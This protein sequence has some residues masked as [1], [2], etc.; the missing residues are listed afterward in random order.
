M[1]NLKDLLVNTQNFLGFAYWIEIKTEI[2]ACTYYFGPFQSQEEA[3]QAQ[4]GYE[5]DL[6]AEAAQGISSVIKQCKP[7][8]LTI[9]EDL[10][11]INGQQTPAYSG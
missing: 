5:D 1:N 6:K 3:Q 2:P 4:Q 9:Y 7:N 10:G 11:E 8:S